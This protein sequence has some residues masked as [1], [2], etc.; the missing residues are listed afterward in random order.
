MKSARS[1]DVAEAT[2][3]S[4]TT[5][6]LDELFE[7]RLGDVTVG[8]DESAMVPVVQRDLPY[9]RELLYNAGKLPKHPVVAMRLRNDTGLTLERGPVTIVEDGQ[10]RGEAI[11]PFTKAGSEL[12]L[13]F[14]VEL[15]ITV[16]LHVTSALQEDSLELR[17]RYL[18][19]QDAATRTRTYSLVNNTDRDEIVTIEQPKSG[20]AELID[21]ATPDE[22]TQEAYRWHVACPARRE[23][24]FT[25][26]DR[27]I[28][29]RREAL[30]DQNLDTLARYLRDRP[31]DAETRDRLTAFLRL[32]QRIADIDEEVE[33]LA[34]E[35][36]A[37]GERQE[38]LRRNLTI[39][40]AS[41][42]EAEIRR[43]SAEEMS[44]QQIREIEIETRSA[45]LRTERQ[46]AEDAL[47]VELATLGADE[48]QPSA[49]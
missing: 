34:A 48:G 32:R 16:D 45:D 47:N 10:Y 7:Y 1:A 43:R 23:A 13:A 2:L 4:A 14:A 25:A 27:S 19:L 11:L 15:G 12:F 39:Q 24:V 28:Y 20:N 5:Q 41:E 40:P 8:K 49:S 35:Q 31:L 9:R 3:L 42:Q 44:R 17:G 37:I 36:S 26:R 6:D 21:T 46:E 18:V 29:R 38:R 30:L 22:E 33:R